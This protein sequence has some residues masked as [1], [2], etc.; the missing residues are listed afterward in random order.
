AG[1]RLLGGPGQLL[2]RLDG[3]AGGAPQEHHLGRVALPAGRAVEGG[4]EARRGPPGPPGGG[5]RGRPDGADAGEAP[6]CGAGGQGEAVRME[7]GWSMTA[8]YRAATHRAASGPTATVVGRNQLSLEAR[9]SRSVSSAARTLRKVTPEGLI[10]W[11][12]TRLWTGSL[13]KTL[14]AKA[15]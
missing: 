10:T 14:P 8:R 6:P 2:Q 15:G 5:A 9:N 1:Q 4:D 3:L 12:W 7:W 11:R 13:M